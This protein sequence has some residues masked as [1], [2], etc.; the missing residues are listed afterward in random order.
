MTQIFIYEIC[1][2]CGCFSLINSRSYV[3]KQSVAIKTETEFVLMTDVHRLSIKIMEMEEFEKPFR[4]NEQGWLGSDCAFSLPLTDERVLWL[5]GDTFVAASKS[6]D[7][8]NREQSK[9]INSSIAIQKKRI[10][11][12][13]GALRFFWNMQKDQP[14]SFFQ[15]HKLAGF[16]WPLSAALVN[17]KIY[18]FAVR[19]VQTDIQSAFGFKQIGNEI[20]C[21]ENPDDTPAAW[22]IR[23][24]YLPFAETGVSFGAY[25]RLYP[26][27]LYLYGY[28]KETDDW[29]GPLN[30]IIA[31]VT[32]DGSTDVADYKSWEYLNGENMT[33]SKDAKR[34]RPVVRHSRSEL[35]VTYLEALKRYVFV[36]NHWKA[37]HPILIRL[38]ETP[39]GPFSEPRT[40]YC[41][42]ET[43]WDPDYFC[44]A[45]KAHPQMVTAKNEL[46]ISYMV[47]SKTLHKCVRDMRIYYPRFIKAVVDGYE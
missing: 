33:W 9:I 32:M 44:Y 23:V 6:K 18:V 41:C 37:P 39:F 30:L 19:I 42:P 8:L 15:N 45:A 7:S 11:T 34:L 4:E 12:S 3:L 38:S 29:Q 2:I 14:Q 22:R 27:Y 36:A 24:S 20:L 10:I 21:I 5:F 47:N 40:I 1:E 28:R 25:A 17:G 26:P 43:E 31:R 13:K 46:V 35:S 16:L